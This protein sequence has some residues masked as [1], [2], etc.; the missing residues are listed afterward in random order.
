[1][2]R[3]PFYRRVLP[4]L[5]A[6]AF[7]CVAP[8]VL[9][10]TA[11][12]R[13]NLK[14]AQ[15]E[16][17][18]TLIADS[19]PKQAE[20]F[21][22]GVDQ[23]DTTPTTFQ[24]L[25]PGRHVVRFEKEGYTSWEKTLEIK[26]ELATFADTIH[27]WKRVPEETLLQ[28]GNFPLL[29]SDPD[30]ELVGFVEV[31]GT[32]QRLHFFS[33]SAGIRE[34]FSL[35]TSTESLPDL[36][37][38]QDGGVL[39]VDEKTGPDLSVKPTFLSLQRTVLPPNDYHWNGTELMSSASSKTSS[40]L[41]SGDFTL[42]TTTSS[43]QQL[44]LDRAF[45]RRAFSLPSGAWTFGELRNSLVLLRDGDDWLGVNPKASNPFSGRI[46]GDYPRWEPNTQK[47]RA[48][49]LNQTEVWLWDPGQPPSL[50]RRQSEPIRNVI[51]HPNGH[52]LFLA[53]DHE[54]IALELD[55]RGGRTTTPIDHFDSIHD[56]AFAGTTLLVS[57]TKNGQ[58]GLW[59]IIVE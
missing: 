7:F 53:T 28:E 16:R 15:L 14:K 21:L 10:Y 27:L 34:D 5:Y 13:Y 56:L 40:D 3:P 18:G 4:W 39:L 29:R 1:M 41:Q 44:L 46:H 57:G 45:R 11:G 19:I 22:D 51:W 59:R 47:P 35:T 43:Q 23:K 55:D 58:S 24:Y 31:S 42:S 38:R 2:Y 8:L 54:V 6:F 17:N 36:R 32:R 48:L 20:I 9:F 26:P 50:L 37:W 49:F 12:Y 52:D 25:T 30:N 33:T